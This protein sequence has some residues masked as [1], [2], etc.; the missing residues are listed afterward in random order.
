[1]TTPHLDPRQAATAEPDTEHTLILARDSSP[2]ELRAGLRSRTLERVRRGAY[3]RI[4]DETEGMLSDERARRATARIHAIEAQLTTPHWFSHESAALIWGCW[5]RLRD[6]ET[7][8]IQDHHPGSGRDRAL[9][10]HNPA[11]PMRDRTEHGGLPVTSLARTVVDVACQAPGGDA[12]M[13][14]DS[15]L[16]LGVDRG[17]IARIVRSRAGHRGIARARLVLA[18]ADARSESPGESTLRWITLDP[19]L[20][21]FVPQVEVVTRAGLFR[22]D[23]GNPKLKIALEFDGAIKYSGRFGP[24]TRVLEEQARRQAALEAEGWIVVRFTWEDLADPGAVVARIQRAVA[25]ASRR[26]SA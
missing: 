19:T 18:A 9:A 20:P 13:V 14:V 3:R 23:L 8:L 6:E 4:D 11:L 26:A 24:A 21:R 7:H 17:Q 1:M 10:R 16:R 12:I 5:V 25:A 2:S 15:A 22:V